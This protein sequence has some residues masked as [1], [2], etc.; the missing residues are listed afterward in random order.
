MDGNARAM[1]FYSDDDGRTWACSRSRCSLPWANTAS[2]L[3]EPG[4]VE[5]A[6][7][8]LWAWAR[9]DL[10]VQYEMFSMDNGETWTASQPSRFSSPCSPLSM[11]RDGNGT[12]YA[13]WNPIPE[14]TG[15]EKKTGIFTGG[16]TPLVLAVSTD[17]GQTF[18]EEAA[19]ETEEDHGYCYCAIHFLEDGMLLAYNGGG[20]E[21]G[22]CLSRI[23][24]R[25]ILWSELEKL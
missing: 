23:K 8:I 16:R 11:K 5:L 3:Q 18:T 6:P 4:L 10:F 13:V 19:F 21:D 24:I 25:R 14:Y 17:N 2:G 1:F 22:S 20:P 9:T 7:G 15:R 12:L